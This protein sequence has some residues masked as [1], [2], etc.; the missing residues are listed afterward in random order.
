MNK[1]RASQTRPIFWIKKAYFKNTPCNAQRRH[2]APY[3]GGM[4]D[5]G[6]FN[7]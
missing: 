3:R 1:G 6:T 7:I 2:E 4:S 5:A